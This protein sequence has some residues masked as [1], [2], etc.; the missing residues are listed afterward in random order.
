[1]WRK[2]DRNNINDIR[3]LEDIC[4]KSGS[5]SVAKE[6]TYTS[7]AIYLTKDKPDNLWCYIYND[8]AF[9]MCTRCSKH[10]RLIFTVVREDMHRKG[11]GKLINNH[12]LRK[13][14]QA[15]IDTVTFRTNQNE[16]AL[17]FWLAQ[18][19]TIV[20]V[21]GNDFEMKLKIKI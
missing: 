2:L 1:M 20:G 9:Y 7:R 4:R 14:K 8:C 15:G 6:R 3:L 11:L 10:I 21:N 13:M 19:A 16:D 17:K 18:G 5:P 12:M